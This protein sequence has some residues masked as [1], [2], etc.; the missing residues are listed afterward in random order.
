[1]AK[2]GASAD[3]CVLCLCRIAVD[4]RS[5]SNSSRDR[6]P[7]VQIEYIRIHIIANTG[8]GVGTSRRCSRQCNCFR[9]VQQFL[10]V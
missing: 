2:S 4:K 7:R 10:A 9:F 8:V 5:M 6:L 1:M 3:A